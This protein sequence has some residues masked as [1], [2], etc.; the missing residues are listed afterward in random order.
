[1]TIMNTP[2]KCGSAL[3]HHRHSSME[4]ADMTLSEQGSLSNST[5]TTDTS[6]SEEEC[7]ST[8]S[9]SPKIFSFVKRPVMSAMEFATAERYFADER[10]QHDKE[11]VRFYWLDQ[12]NRMLRCL[13]Q[14][15]IVTFLVLILIP[16]YIITSH[17]IHSSATPSPTKRFQPHRLEQRWKK[18]LDSKGPAVLKSIR[19]QQRTLQASTSYTIRLT[20]TRADLVRRSIDSHARCP[21]VGK[22]QVQGFPASPESSEKIE[23]WGKVSTEGI[24]LLT[25]DVLLSC[26]ELDRAFQMWRVHS[27]RLVG[28]FPALHGHET[29]SQKRGE[30]KVEYNFVS[31]NVDGNYSLVSSRAAFVHS[32]YVKTF[33]ESN[34][35][36]VGDSGST[37]LEEEACSPFGLSILVTAISSLPP[38]AVV[39]DPI[40]LRR[41]CSLLRRLKGSS[42]SLERPNEVSACLHQWVEGHGMHDLPLEYTMYLGV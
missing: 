22:I 15:T 6:C 41:T 8:G 7:E 31:G 4:T 20:G 36:E 33:E 13:R 3:L 21:H 39:A 14:R 9:A 5:S 26:D 2:T 23:E 18:H 17:V 40:E 19:A 24:L 38:I 29:Y 25:D 37:A 35:L 34:K 12:K 16:L 28:F 42:L 27:D 10:E 11:C 30:R 1:M 32:L